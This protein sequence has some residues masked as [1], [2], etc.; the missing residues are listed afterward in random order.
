MCVALINKTMALS[1]RNMIY[2]GLGALVVGVLLFVLY[3]RGDISLAAADTIGCGGCPA[4]QAC[5][6]PGCG[7][8]EGCGSCFNVSG[9]YAQKCCPDGSIVKTS[10]MCPT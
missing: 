8:D 3:R 10:R 5:C 4:G 2:L 7:M 9:K 6:N 1:Q